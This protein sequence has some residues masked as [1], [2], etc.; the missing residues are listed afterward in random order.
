MAQSTNKKV[1]LARFDREPVEGFVQA[2]AGFEGEAIEVLTPSG[3]L[4]RIPVSET[5]AVCFVRD[6]EAGETWR[7][8]R[9]FLTRPKMPGVWVRLLFRDGDSVEGMVPNN[10][11]LVETAGFSIIPPDPTF[12]NQRIFVP[13]AALR[14]VQVLGVV[15]S[16]LR[17]PKTKKTTAEE[18]LEMFGDR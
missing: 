4:L 13:R 6:F 2:S 7:E 9:T 18:Q 5:K 3:T 1:L 8:H 14:E 12:Q 10:L 15:G 11:M 16:P 17:R